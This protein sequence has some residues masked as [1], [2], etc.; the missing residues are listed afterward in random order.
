MWWDDRTVLNLHSV[1]TSEQGSTQGDHEKDA[2][3]QLHA[4]VDLDDPYLRCSPPA[5]ACD[6][7]AL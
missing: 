3:K 6:G 5:A 4:S 2:E 7:V 1:L